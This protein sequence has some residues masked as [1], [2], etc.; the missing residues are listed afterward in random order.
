MPFTSSCLRAC[1]TIALLFSPSLVHAQG[2]GS[3]S[4]VQVAAGGG[5]LTSGAYFTGPGNLELANGD[6]FVAALQ[7]SV[8]VHQS[9][10]LVFAAAYARSEWHLTGLPLLGPVRSPGASLWFADVGLRGQ[11]PLGQRGRAPAVFAQAGPGFARYGLSTSVLGTAVDERATNFA[12][13]VGAGLALP[14]T[15]RLAVEVIAKDYI[16]SFKSVRD[17]AAFGI[18]GRRAHT[19]VL[20]GSGRLGL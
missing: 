7:V 3:P 20:L 9:V 15:R 16:A 1:V 12:L 5:L 17:L 11:V 6:A 10:A 19:L 14:L 13:A 18:E 8:A 4:R 2:V